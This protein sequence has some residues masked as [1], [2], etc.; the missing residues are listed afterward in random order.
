MLKIK[1]LT[2]IRRLVQ[3]A[4]PVLFVTPI[5]ASGWLLFGATTGT[6]EQLARPADLPFWGSLSSSTIFKAVLA[7]PFAALE[8]IAASHSISTGLL[9]AAA[10]PLLV[11]AVIGGRTFCGWVCPVNLLLEATDWLR[12]KL[13]GAR[14]G[15]GGLS[16]CEQSAD[17]RSVFNVR[18]RLL[19]RHTKIFVAGGLLLF[20]ATT[21]WLLFENLSPIAAL[22]KSWLFGSSAGLITILAII[23]VE[24]FLARRLWCR[25]L[26]PIGGLYQLT[27]RFG[28]L[29]VRIDHKACTHCNRCRQACIADPKILDPLLERCHTSPDIDSRHPHGKQDNQQPKTT[30][31]NSSDC[32]R[33]GKCVDACPT[34]ALSMRLF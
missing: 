2:L 17:W 1:P 24:M 19:P 27:G 33:C 31:L 4:V 8:V 28:I 29:K 21:N 23:L 10:I 9:L 6:E 13:A 7:D 11:Y 15:N 3:L 18:E 20:S 14:R 12:G 16:G 34:K 26:C 30:R 32:L 25:A 5:I 22:T